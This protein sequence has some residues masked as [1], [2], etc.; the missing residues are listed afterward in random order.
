MR[1][2]LRTIVLI[3]PL[4][5]AALSPAQFG[6]RGAISEAARPDV[7]PR[8][9]ILIMDTL[10]LEEWQRPIVESLIED[11]T[12]SF[13]TG[14]ETAVQKMKEYASKM[15]GGTAG[16]K[17]MM[18]PIAAWLPEKKR[19][20]DE[21]MANVKGQLSD[22]QLERWPRFER[23]MRREKSLED[24]DLAG[25]GLDL[26]GIVRQMQVP[27]D[28]MEAAQP[29]IDAYEVELDTALVQRDAAIDG[30]AG[31]LTDAMES[32]D[33]NRGFEVQMQIMNARVGV[34]NVQDT[35]IEKI[36]EALPA[37]YGPQFRERALGMGYREAF[38]PDALAPFFQTVLALQGLTDDQRS[39]IEQIQ[40]KWAGE[41]GDLRE[42]MV[43]ALRVD[44]PSR[45]KRDAA[46]RAAKSGGDP[47]AGPKE[48][49]APLRAEKSKLVNAT[50]E[51]VKALLTPEQV[52]AL[53]GGD[54][55]F[56]PPVPTSPG[57]S[58]GGAEVRA[59]VGTVPDSQEEPSGLPEGRKPGT[60]RP[61]AK[62]A[63]GAG[64]DAP[65]DPPQ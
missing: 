48:A 62:P 2:L 15:K 35:W 16:A 50:R 18:Q 23:A 58:K 27:K 43:A 37:P 56:R 45:P 52:D 26:G 53:A 20:Y 40:T 6:G 64:G 46:A 10:K 36:A 31:P 54:S 33:V 13:K 11:Y 49:M 24:S 28:A 60:K 9:A 47:S 57:G 7:L 4:F 32:G 30:L 12:F 34:R 17:G 3:A 29:A 63:D 51:Q 55:N 21:F 61:P 44:G 25:E 14:W 22:V 59:P 39:A 41:L 1:T 5:L 38:Q 65:K 42:R 19:L 8:D